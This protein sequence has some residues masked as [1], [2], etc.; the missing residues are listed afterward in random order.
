VKSGRLSPS[1]RTYLPFLRALVRAVAQRA[2]A[3]RLVS[4]MPPPMW[5][6]WITVFGAFGALGAAVGFIA[7]KGITWDNCA[8]ALTVA[9]LAIAPVSYLRVLR[10][11]GTRPLDPNEI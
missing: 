8:F 11:L 5:W 2:P 4:G 10:R 1:T 7:Q 9:L 6:F 3:A